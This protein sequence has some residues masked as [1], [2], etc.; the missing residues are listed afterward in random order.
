MADLGEVDIAGLAGAAVAGAQQS[1]VRP[2]RKNVAHGAAGA[3]AGGMRR[4]WGCSAVQRCSVSLLLDRRARRSEVLL[5][6]VDAG[7]WVLGKQQR[8]MMDGKP[9]SEPLTGL[10][11]KPRVKLH[12]SR[13]NNNGEEASRRPRVGLEAV[14]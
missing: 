13:S 3:Q 7:C 2:A 8:R 6:V 12:R 5:A 9:H 14:P 4:R 11:R 10:A 1:V